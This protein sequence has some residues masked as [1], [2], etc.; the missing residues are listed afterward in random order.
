MDRLAFGSCHFNKTHTNCVYVQTIKEP[1]T[2]TTDQPNEIEE[3]KKKKLAKSAYVST[4]KLNQMIVYVPP[5]SY[6]FYLAMNKSA[7]GK[8]FANNRQ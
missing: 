8:S 4:R 5:F 3:R 7:S 6:S 1:T 2:T